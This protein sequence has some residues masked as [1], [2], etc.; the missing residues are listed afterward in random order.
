MIILSDSCIIDC[1]IKEIRSFRIQHVLGKDIMLKHSGPQ[2]EQIIRDRII[3]AI[4]L[5]RRVLKCV[6]D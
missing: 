2:I 6:A 4:D 5:H 1:I 3:R